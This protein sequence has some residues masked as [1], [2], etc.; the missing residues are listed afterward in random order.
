MKINSRFFFL[1]FTLIGNIVLWVFYDDDLFLR[2]WIFSFL[3]IIINYLYAY[4]SIRGIVIKRSSR[5]LRH[6]V[7]DFFEENFELFN[8]SLIWVIWLELIDHSGI[9]AHEK[10][11]IF[12]LIAPKKIRTYIT[13]SLLSKRGAFKLGPMEIFSGDPFG[14]FS[15]SRKIKGKDTLVVLPYVVDI[16]RFV[17]LPGYLMGGNIL[18]KTSIEATPYAAGIREYL[19]GD[20]LNRIHWP[21][22]VKRGKLMVKEFDRDPQMNAWIF[23]DAQKEVHV[24]RINQ[25]IEYDANSLW[26]LR[27][28]HQ[29]SLPRSTMEYAVSISASIIKFYLKHKYAAG[30]A[31]TGRKINLIPAEKGDRQLGK[32]L[33]ALAFV[34][35][36]GNI[37]LVSL[38]EWQVKNIPRGSMIVLVTPSQRPS[39]ELAVDI[40]LSHGLKPIVILFDNNSFG[41]VGASIGLRNRITLHHVPT[42][43]VKYGED[44]KKLLESSDVFN[45]PRMINTYK[46]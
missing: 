19:P 28:K 5:G 42:V 8:K 29:F 46:Y 33:E 34:K 24:E 10:E 21:T 32:L 23:L 2:L 43:M 12:S 44:I 15:V 18:R 39:I 4:F 7:G 40:T 25:Q 36:N 45:Y 20:P 30:L 14:I 31:I 38:I 1:L 16:N 41:G 26:F 35:C 17:Y 22:T 3:I 27:K 6:E 9:S 37:P 13:Y 11:R